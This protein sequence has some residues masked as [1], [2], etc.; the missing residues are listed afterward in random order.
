[1]SPSLLGSKAAVV[2]SVDG[3]SQR[4]AVRVVDLDRPVG[5]VIVPTARRPDAIRTCLES[6]RRLDYPRFRVLV[7]DNAPEEP[8]TREVVEA[9]AEEDERIHYLAEPRPGSSVARNRGIAESS[10]DILAFTDDDV[11]VDPRWLAWLVHG[12]QADPAVTV[13][14]GLVMPTDMNT[15]AQ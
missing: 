2:A 14:T 10:T 9:V 15:P 1:M 11:S 6:L 12:F 13:V 4:I 3:D 7:V 8:A 5:D